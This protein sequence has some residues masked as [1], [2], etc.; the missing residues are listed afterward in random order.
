MEEGMKDDRERLQC[1]ECIHGN[2]DRCVGC[3]CRVCY[4]LYGIPEEDNG[5][6]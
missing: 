3:I 5:S 1:V 4:E 2:H 6:E